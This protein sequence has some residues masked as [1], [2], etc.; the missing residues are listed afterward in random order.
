MFTKDELD[1]LQQF[2][3]KAQSADSDDEDP[4]TMF[5]KDELDV[6]RQYAERVRAE[7]DTDGDA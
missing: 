5:T 4:T 3:A 2:H 7:R 6:L 1:Q